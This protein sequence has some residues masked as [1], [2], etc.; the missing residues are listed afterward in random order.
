[1]DPIRGIEVRTPCGHY[2]DKAC[3]LQLFEGASKDESLFPPRCCREPIPIDSVAPHMTSVALATF[4]GKT[5]EFGTKK[6][7]YCANRSCSRFLGA[8]HEGTTAFFRP[9]LPY[10]KCTARGC[11]TTTC[12]SCKQALTTGAFHRCTTNPDDSRVLALGRESGWARCPGC[13]TMIELNLGC[14]H[15]TCRCRTQFCYLCRERW[16]TCTCP[17]WD[18]GRLLSAAEERAD[19]QLRQGALARGGPRIEREPAARGPVRVVAAPARLPARAGDPATT[20]PARGAAQATVAR[21]TPPSPAARRSQGTASSSTRPLST[22]TRPSSTVTSNADSSTA[23]RR[24]STMH[25]GLASS[26]S[27]GGLHKVKTE[28]ER[29]VRMWMDHLR[30]D[31][32]CNHVNWTYRRGAGKCES[33]HDRLPLYLFRCDGCSM[34]ACRRCRWNR[35]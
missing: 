32:D 9:Q 20:T 6:R 14:Y 27:R 21:P 5:V 24:P 15:M 12:S 19:A 10:F 4:M 2:Y 11:N 35:L 34:M 26:S 16:K 23:N 25:A 18:E 3:I 29:L 30:V 22:T 8:Q 17:Q 33:C 13:E 28:R 7:V 31:H 1:M